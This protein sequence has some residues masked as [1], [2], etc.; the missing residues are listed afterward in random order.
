MM[1]SDNLLTHKI[2]TIKYLA[3]NTV[4]FEEVAKLDGEAVKHVETKAGG[5]QLVLLC[6]RVHM[7]SWYISTELSRN[8]IVF[9]NLLVKNMVCRPKPRGKLVGA[10]QCRI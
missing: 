3:N 7:Q 4:L 6:L 10:Y 5:H 8:K 9:S 2:R 1:T